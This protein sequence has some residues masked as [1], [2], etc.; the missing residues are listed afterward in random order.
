MEYIDKSVTLLVVY[1]YWLDAEHAPLCTQLNLKHC[2]E[3]LRKQNFYFQ[4][5]NERSYENA[6][7]NTGTVV[8]ARKRLDAA[9]TNITKRIDTSVYHGLSN[10]EMPNFILRASLQIKRIKTVQAWRK[11]MCASK[12]RRDAEKE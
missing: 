7:K 1:A 2:V 4:K 3:A 12:K 11:S 5:K 9:Y 10:N 6:Y 8:D